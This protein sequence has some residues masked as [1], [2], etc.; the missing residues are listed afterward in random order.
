MHLRPI[1]PFFADCSEYSEQFVDMLKW[2]NPS[3]D[4]K[5][6]NLRQ[7]IDRFNVWDIP[8]KVKVESWEY[9][10][11][12]R[13]IESKREIEGKKL[14]LILFSFYNHQ[15]ELGPPWNPLSTG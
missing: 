13:V 3:L 9:T 14:R 8:V 4:P 15:D 5:F 12:T 2:N 10:F 6:P 11:Q 7:I 1:A